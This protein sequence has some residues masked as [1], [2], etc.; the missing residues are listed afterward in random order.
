[1]PIGFELFTMRRRP[2]LDQPGSGTRPQAVRQD[3]TVEPEGRSLALMLCMEEGHP[4]LAGGHADDDTKT[5]ETAGTW[6]FPHRRRTAA[7]PHRKG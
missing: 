4:T 3:F 5:V 7:Q 6:D 1:M 2:L